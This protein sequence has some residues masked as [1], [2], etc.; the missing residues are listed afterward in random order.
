MADDMPRAVA[1]AWRGRAVSTRGRRPGLGLGTIV[2]A[3]LRVA[4]ADGL[5]AVSMSRV[6][7]ELGAATMSLYRHVQ[8]KDE[9]LAHMVDA[10]FAGAP[11]TP[12]PDEPWR[13][14]LT[15]WALQYLAVLRRHRWLV[16]VPVSGPPLM[17][18]QVLWFERGLQCLRGTA[19]PQAEKPAVLLLVDGFVRNQATLEADLMQAAQAS[20]VALEEAGAA[21]ARVLG[22]LVDPERFPAVQALLDARTFEPPG[23]PA[24]GVQFGLDLI[25]DGIEVL[26]G[27]RAQK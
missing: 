23:T 5:G 21:Y 7:S 16:R 17:P 10:A 2:D 11:G 6:A 15:R 20:G 27:R 24:D 3:A 18:N 12:A 1:T 4:L 14:G 19:L 25:L 26:I 8:A 13:A 22:G 9:L